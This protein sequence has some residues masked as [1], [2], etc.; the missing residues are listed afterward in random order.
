MGFWGMLSASSVT[1]G[2]ICDKMYNKLRFARL[3][4]LRRRTSTEITLSMWFTISED[5]NGDVK[6][7]CGSIDIHNVIETEAVALLSVGMTL[8]FSKFQESVLSLAPNDMKEEL[9]GRL[10]P[11]IFSRDKLGLI[12]A[13]YV[14]NE[15][16]VDIPV[17]EKKVLWHDALASTRPL[18]AVT[19]EVLSNRYLSDK[20]DT[21]IMDTI[22]QILRSNNVHRNCPLSEGDSTTFSGGLVEGLEE[23]LPPQSRLELAALREDTKE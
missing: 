17:D 14:F 9:R 16:E 18:A 19:F 15:K 1:I 4:N 22:L 3:K 10:A 11:D 5:T 6:A 13:E 7:L 12:F 21:N 23:T 20:E 2:Q 8:S